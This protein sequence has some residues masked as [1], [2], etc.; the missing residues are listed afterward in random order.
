MPATCLGG[1][2]IQHGGSGSH[3]GARNL[4]SGGTL[5]IR[6]RGGRAARGSAVRAGRGRANRPRRA[7][8]RERDGNAL[9]RGTSC[10]RPTHACGEAVHA[11][12]EALKRLELLHRALQN[13]VVQV[14]H[15]RCFGCLLCHEGGRGALQ[16]RLCSE[17]S[18]TGV[19]YAQA[20]LLRAQ[21]NN[22]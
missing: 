2:G 6:R 7:A 19:T 15:Q 13:Q 11:R 22:P 3:F 8:R 4:Y 17:L 9:W 21:D 16:R 18:F 10:I 14:A 12:L 5:V 20:R 1:S